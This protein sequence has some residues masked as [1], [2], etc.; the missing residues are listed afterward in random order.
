M[1][2]TTK[3]LVKRDISGRTIFNN[4]FVVEVCEKIHLHYRNLR[5][6]LD[7]SDFVAFTRGCAQALE[8]WG[9]LGQ[10]GP[11]KGQHIELC[12][13]KVATEAHNDGI[14]VNLNENLY[15]RNE[16]KIYAEGAEVKDERYI[17]LKIRDLRLELSIK[18]FEEV[19]D[20]IVEA[21][22]ELKHSDSGA[23]LQK[24]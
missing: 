22:K 4:R 21:Q 6:T 15:N 18:E 13:K 8:R 7:V 12:R 2:R 17:H 3:K 23:L 24:A 5:I 11:G 14:Q 10:P 20:A 9:K 19:A 1:G 16:G